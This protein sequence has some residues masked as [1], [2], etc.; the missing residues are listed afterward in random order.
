MM[1][2]EKTIN[3][4]R[5]FSSGGRGRRA[6][7]LIYLV[8]CVVCTTSR[9]QA[10]LNVT[11]FGAKGDAV[12]FYA[13]TVSNSVIVTTTNVFSPA[14]IGKSIEV[15]GAGAVTY[16]RNTTGGTNGNQDLIA[17]LT[18]VVN[19]TN[20][21]ISQLPQAN[22]TST[23]TTV[24]T[25]NST[26]FQNA[27]Q[28]AASS[29]T[30]VTINVPAGKYLC[31]GKRILFT[32]VGIPVYAGG[33]HLVGEGTNKTVLL[34]QGA[35]RLDNPG[36]LGV[37][38]SMLLAIVPPVTNDY[39][40]SIENIN[41]DGGVEH[42]AIS[43]KSVYANQ[44][45]G[46]GW[47]VSHDAIDIRGFNGHS[48]TQWTITNCLFTRWRGEVLKSNGGDTNGNL[49]II[50]CTF[51]DGNASALNIYPS[52]IVTNCIFDNMYQVAEYY[53]KYSTNTSYFVCNL[54]TNIYN[55]AFSINGG[56]GSNPSYVISNN[57][58]YT[59]MAGYNQIVTC[60]GDNVFII[61]NRFIALAPAAGHCG[62]I[63]IGSMGYQSPNNSCNSNIVIYGNTFSN[64][65]SV[66]AFG[67][68]IS[69][70]VNRTDGLIFAGNTMTEDSGV[71]GNGWYDHV[72]IYSNTVLDN[73]PNP[74][75]GYKRFN[76][77]V[78]EYGQPLV[79]MQ[80]NNDIWGRIAGITPNSTNFVS[81]ANGTRFQVIYKLQSNAVF[82]LTDTNA[83][84]IPAGAQILIWNT[85]LNS[86]N[87]TGTNS[88][89]VY[90][91]SS[92]TGQAVSV[93]AQAV[94]VFNWNGSAWQTNAVNSNNSA[95][96]SESLNP[97]TL[98]RIMQ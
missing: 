25:D 19:G 29:G 27:I 65:S 68:S 7:L 21:Y 14:D 42:G 49:T 51:R 92:A 13:N 24:G 88:V 20:L 39:P 34:G 30:N 86:D 94:T 78:R 71:Y 22:T 48:F 87:S 1:H 85:T 89:Q 32:Y 74:V 47:D 91:D 41:F 69:N 31:M 62:G 2:F 96:N 73:A 76:F 84:T 82:A 3:Y 81:Y 58:F 64:V 63:V 10:S 17:T 53:Q 54:I 66:L 12:Q 38:R 15:T 80:T 44:V 6:Y 70:S 61:S 9:A 35:W 90:L 59:L 55:N 33:W 95:T 8:L 36:G 67:N 50:N 97:P 79:L 4:S 83:A 56:I 11:N 26:A 98:L 52:Q 93:P 23:F 77:C 46:C 5:D 18:N 72:Q 43:Y 57:T 40:V 45:D 16:G 28:D 37:Y 75:Q 60:P